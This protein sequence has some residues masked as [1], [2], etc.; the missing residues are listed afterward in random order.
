[1]YNLSSSK[2]GKT[3]TLA[4]NGVL[5]TCPF[6][7][8]VAL[9]LGPD[10]EGNMRFSIQSAMCTSNCALFHITETKDKSF[11]VKLL[12]GSTFQTD[13]GEVIEYLIP[14]H[15]AK[16]GEAGQGEGVTKKLVN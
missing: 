7:T 16:S 11:S 4:R 8:R 13:N 6:A 9:P 10:L 3:V 14:A 15:K 5:C 2:D 1:M 12:C